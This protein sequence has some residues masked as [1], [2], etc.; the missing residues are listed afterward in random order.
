MANNCY[1]EMKIVG[2]KKDVLIFFDKIKNK[3]L[4]C[5]IYSIDI[6]EENFSEGYI[7]V[8]GDCAWGVCSA[9]IEYPE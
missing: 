4:K 8:F 5:R 6:Y 1:F 9:M 3:K 2:L 7:E